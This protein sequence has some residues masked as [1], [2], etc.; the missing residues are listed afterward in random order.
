VKDRVEIERRMRDKAV[1]ECRG[2]EGL[3]RRGI[4]SRQ[5]LLGSLQSGVLVVR[6]CCV[7]CRLG[8]RVCHVEG[9]SLVGGRSVLSARQKAMSSSKARAFSRQPDRRR[10]VTGWRYL[11]I[12]H[13]MP[14]HYYYLPPAHQIL[15][16]A[17]HHHTQGKGN[18]SG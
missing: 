8:V 9:G 18:P 5:S 7:C 14:L 11:S 13:V 6:I 3:G 4:G 16:I 15:Q 2:G 1:K 12:L 10:L 17:I